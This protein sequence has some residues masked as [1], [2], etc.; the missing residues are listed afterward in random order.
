MVIY[1]NRTE[2]ELKGDKTQRNEAWKTVRKSVT[3]LK[4]YKNVLIFRS[5]I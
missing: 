4:D 1:E 2:Q 5:K 3:I